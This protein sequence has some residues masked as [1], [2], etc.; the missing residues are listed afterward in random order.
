MTKPPCSSCQHRQYPGCK[1]GCSQFA[2]WDKKRE[3]AAERRRAAEKA[4]RD[5]WGARK[6]WRE[7]RK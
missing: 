4:D 1:A 5:Y 2:Q 6:Q 7:A 3:Q